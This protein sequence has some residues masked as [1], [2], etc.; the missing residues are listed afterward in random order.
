MGVPITPVPIQPTR[1]SDGAAR[2]GEYSGRGRAIS[3]S[4]SGVIRFAMACTRPSW[5]MAIFPPLKLKA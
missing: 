4:T 3:Y 5:S 1:V 2:R